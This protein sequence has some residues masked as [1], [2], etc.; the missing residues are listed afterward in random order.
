MPL[1]SSDKRWA[2]VILS[3]LREMNLPPQRLIRAF[4]SGMHPILGAMSTLLSM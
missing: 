1:K 2:E 4:G 3:I